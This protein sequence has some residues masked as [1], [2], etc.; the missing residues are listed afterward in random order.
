MISANNVFLFW[1]TGAAVLREV[2]GGLGEA[3][4]V[5]LLAQRPLRGRPATCRKQL[6]GLRQ[7]LLEP[8]LP[9]QDT[10]EA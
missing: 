5:V 6:S 9:G 1:S 4:A 3:V 10:Q 2:S 7:V 8:S